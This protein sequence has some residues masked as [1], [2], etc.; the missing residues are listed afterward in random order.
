[1]S[2][3]DPEVQSG[4]RSHAL[5]VP[6]D[7]NRSQLRRNGDLG[8]LTLLGCRRIAT[9]FCR[10]SY[11]SDRQFADCSFVPGASQIRGLREFV[12]EGGNRIVD[13][14]TGET[15]LPEVDVLAVDRLDTPGDDPAL[16]RHPAS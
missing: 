15:A 7:Q 11:H 3:P 10:L 1:M 4:R 13:Q 8:L 9:L 12:D 2:P 6:T 16:V 14:F 5:D